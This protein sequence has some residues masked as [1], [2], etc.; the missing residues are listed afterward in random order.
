M[1][2]GIYK[3]QPN[4]KYG[5][6]GWRPGELRKCVICGKEFYIKPSHIKKRIGVYCS[7]KCRIEGMKGRK[8]PK[9]TKRKLSLAHGG[10]GTPNP[11][12]GKRYYHQKDK[13]YKEWRAKVFLRDNFTCQVCREV[14][15]FLHPH[16]I[17]SW[18]KYPKLRYEVS[19]GITL[20]VECHKEIHKLL[21]KNHSH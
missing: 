6:T 20:C 9:E 18:A 17:K 4:I 16:H 10:T 19:N 11:L 7:N 13:K 21:R 12:Y 5:K 14:G 2:K 8:L 15:C 3:R 1:P